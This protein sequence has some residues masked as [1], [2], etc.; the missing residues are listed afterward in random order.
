MDASALPCSITSTGRRVQVKVEEQTIRDDARR[1]PG[2]R[3]ESQRPLL[4]EPTFLR[5]RTVTVSGNGQTKKPR[6]TGEASA[7]QN[8]QD[9]CLG[10]T[11]RHRVFH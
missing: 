10:N 2:N 6:K 11:G 9:E 3:R 1:A 5:R 8:Q 7:E 4:G